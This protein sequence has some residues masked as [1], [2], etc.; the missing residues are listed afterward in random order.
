[1]RRKAL[2]RQSSVASEK[3]RQIS[4]RAEAHV[5]A[6]YNKAAQAI[7]STDDHGKFIEVNPAFQNMF[8]YTRAEALKLTHLDITAPEYR[9]VSKEK[10]QALFHH[11]IESYRLEKIYVRKDG[12]FFW[13]DV[14]VAAVHTPENRVQS[15][16]IIVDISDRKK[17][18]EDLK[19]AHDELERRVTERTAE[20]A[21]ANREL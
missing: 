16:A 9:P 14:S 10:A 5:R 3:T 6:L 8:G 4:P 19:R 20:L 2:T 1:M 15:A 11:E 17:A 12:S 13:G 7:A 18:E 21:S